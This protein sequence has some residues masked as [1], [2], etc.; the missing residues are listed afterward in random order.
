MISKT[1]VSFAKD[2]SIT[3][4]ITKVIKNAEVLYEKCELYK[5]KWDKGCPTPMAWCDERDFNGAV[6]GY[7]STELIEI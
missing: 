3:G 5:V 4:T 7:K 6:K 1:R 2:S